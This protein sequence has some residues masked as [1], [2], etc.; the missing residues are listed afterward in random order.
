MILAPS[1]NSPVTSL[2]EAYFISSDV[3]GFSTLPFSS[4][5]GAERGLRQPAEDEAV[6]GRV[7]GGAERYR[8]SAG[9]QAW[10]WALWVS[11]TVNKKDPAGQG[12]DF[13][14]N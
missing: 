10:G 7:P 4:I 13:Y 14:L 2:P 5:R 11:L 12:R 1:G 3:A 9:V 6:A 8:R